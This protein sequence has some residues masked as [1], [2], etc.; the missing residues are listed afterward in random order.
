[1]KKKKKSK[2]VPALKLEALVDM[3]L[4]M[5]DDDA[6]QQTR[7]AKKM[8]VKEV[9]EMSKGPVTINSARSNRLSIINDDEES[10]S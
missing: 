4:D 9:E 3:D 1:M 10:K 6:S 7:F 2:K 5:D 8:T